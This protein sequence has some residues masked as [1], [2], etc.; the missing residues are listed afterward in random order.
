MQSQKVTR[1]ERDG[2]V[3]SAAVVAEL[4]FEDSRSEKR[5]NGT[6][7]SADETGIG[8][9]VH[10]SDDRKQLEIGHSPSFLYAAVTT[11]R[12]PRRELGLDRIT[13]STS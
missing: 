10:Q 7:L 9:I 11:I 2:C 12:A 8:H 6:H 1:I 13:I 5:N 4:H 3:G